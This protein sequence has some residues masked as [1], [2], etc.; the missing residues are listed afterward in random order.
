MNVCRSKTWRQASVDSV[1]HLTNRL[2]QSRIVS[3]EIDLRQAITGDVKLLRFEYSSSSRYEDFFSLQEFFSR[4][5]PLQVFFFRGQVPCTNFIIVIFF[6]FFFLFFFFCFFLEGV[7]WGKIFYCRTRRNPL[8][9][10]EQASNKFV[11][12]FAQSFWFT[13]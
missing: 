1:R 13:V 2:W 6:F 11:V 12:F 9:F 8:N 4:P 7:D 3:P 5:L 10:L